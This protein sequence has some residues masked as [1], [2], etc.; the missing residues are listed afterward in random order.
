MR[1]THDLPEKPVVPLA[2]TSML[3]SVIKENRWIKDRYVGVTTCVT[4]CSRAM[5]S[6]RVKLCDVCTPMCTDSLKL[7]EEMNVV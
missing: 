4:D 7:E 6:V 5:L 3:T 2:R 1:N